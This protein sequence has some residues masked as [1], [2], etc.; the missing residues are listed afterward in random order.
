MSCQKT[1]IQSPWNEWLKQ[2]IDSTNIKSQ[3]IM[4]K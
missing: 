3:M 4:V 2:I 1:W